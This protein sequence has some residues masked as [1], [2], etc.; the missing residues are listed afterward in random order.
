MSRFI[1]SPHEIAAIHLTGVAASRQSAAAGIIQKVRR[2]RA[3]ARPILTCR[4]TIQFVIQKRET[5]NRRRFHAQGQFAER[6]GFG[7]GGFNHFQF[8]KREIAFRPD[9]HAGTARQA[10]VLPLKFLKPFTRLH[11]RFALDDATCSGLMN[12]LDDRPKVA[13][14]PWAE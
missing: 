10:S 1:F 13:S 5:I 4:R 3:A 8:I 6:D 12:L 7:P 11:H 14:Q 2:G 9:P